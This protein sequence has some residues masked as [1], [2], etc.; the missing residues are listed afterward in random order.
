MSI[1]ELKQFT[2]SHVSQAQIKALNLDLRRRESWEALAQVAC[3]NY[4]AAENDD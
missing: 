1:A 4:M 3:S 2:L